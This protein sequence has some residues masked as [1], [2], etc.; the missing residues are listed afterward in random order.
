[1]TT[2][3]PQLRIGDAHETQAARPGRAPTDLGA[4][5]EQLA[6]KLASDHG[7]QFRLTL[8][9]LSEVPAGY[10]DTVKDCAIQMLRNAAVHGIEPC[11]TRRTAAKPEIGEVRLEFRRLDPGYELVFQDDGAG[12]APEA[13]KEAAVRK[14]VITTEEAAALDNRAALAL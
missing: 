2:S 6:G 12:L 7:K 11:E 10:L 3:L 9:G 5:L 14:N 13:L 8:S 4:L 1:G